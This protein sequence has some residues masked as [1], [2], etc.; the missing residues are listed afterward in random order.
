MP[1]HAQ[2]KALG[3]IGYQ[4]NGGTPPLLYNG[5]P[6]MHTPTVYAIYWVPKT[7]QDGTST[8]LSSTYQNVE[9]T[10]LKEYFGHSLMNNNTQYYDAKY[11]TNTGKVGGTYVDK[12]AYPGSDCFDPAV[13]AGLLT[14][15]SNCISDLDLQN[16][17]TKVMGIKHWTGGVNKLFM[18]FTS[19]NEG[20]CAVSDSDCSYY[21]YCAYHS[22]FVN[23]S[24]EDVVYSNE[25]YGNT[26]VCQV[27]G[28][29]SPNGFPDADTAA[30]ASAHELTESITDPLLNAWLDSSGYEIGDECAYYYG[31]ALWDGG[32]ATE[33]GAAIRFTYRPCTTI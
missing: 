11:I 7:L 26:T 24:G 21:T 17:A 4:H 23:G 32:L 19:S 8:S 1:T 9:T 16:E 25:P 29:P 30:T 14:N 5:G 13:G 18:V 12:S 31:V 27:A 2:A 20:Q 6:A 33:R 3:S 15:G 22:Y 28:A 10:M